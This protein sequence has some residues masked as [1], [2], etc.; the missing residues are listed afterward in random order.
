MC[1]NGVADDDL[2][3]E[4]KVSMAKKR[5]VELEKLIE[6]SYSSIKY[7]EVEISKIAGN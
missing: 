5:V 7:R 2:Y 4:G 6:T 3:N 1:I